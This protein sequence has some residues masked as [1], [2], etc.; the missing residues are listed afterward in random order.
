MKAS[1]LEIRCQANNKKI[2]E[3]KPATARACEKMTS[4]NALH[5][6]NP[7]GET[8]EA[9]LEQFYANEPNPSRS[10]KMEIAL[11]LK[12]SPQNIGRWF[13]ARKR[14]DAGQSRVKRKTQQ[15]IDAL[16]A[17]FD[18]NPFPTREEKDAIIA[19][20]GLTLKE[21]N[22]WFQFSRKKRGLTDLDNMKGGAPLKSWHLRVKERVRGTSSEPGDADSLGLPSPGLLSLF[23][24]D[25]QT[26]DASSFLNQ[27][28]LQPEQSSNSLDSTTLPPRPPRRSGSVA[29]LLDHFSSSNT[30]E[31]PPTRTPPGSRHPPSI[32]RFN[33]YASSS[34]SDTAMRHQRTVSSASSRSITSSIESSQSR[35]V[36]HHADEQPTT[37]SAAT[38]SRTRPNS[39][40]F[41]EPVLGG[42][43]GAPFE[44]IWEAQEQSPLAS[45]VSPTA[46]FFPASSG[47]WELG[48]VNGSEPGTPESD[49]PQLG[50]Q[51]NGF[52]ISNS[53]PPQPSLQLPNLS[54]TKS[55]RP[56]GQQQ[57]LGIIPLTEE[58]LQHLRPFGYPISPAS[59]TLPTQLGQAAPRRNPL[60]TS[61][62]L[63]SDRIEVSN[64]ALPSQLPLRT[65]ASS[66]ASSVEAAIQTSQ[67]F[68]KAPGPYNRPVTSVTSNLQHFVATVP[69]PQNSFQVPPTSHHP[70][71][72]PGL[73]RNHTPQPAQVRTL[74]QHQ[75]LN[76]P[77]RAAT[78]SAYIV[79]HPHHQLSAQS[80]AQYVGDMRQQQG[81][82]ALGQQGIPY[83]PII[84]VSK[85]GGQPLSSQQ[86]QQYAPT[87][88]RN[89]QTPQLSTSSPQQYAVMPLQYTF[90]S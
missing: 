13:S 22:A 60:D 23:D 44:P 18:R 10:V 30:D 52:S 8:E 42:M 31:A 70:G 56:S 29:S 77:Q 90:N 49:A 53:L 41:T 26:F 7:I 65:S 34:T 2:P 15:Q 84:F 74:S 64:F 55:D 1:R 28:L 5:G 38:S 25:N 4:S 78:P 39:G 24:D 72:F 87:S 59:P 62:L 3:R 82:Q 36:V 68:L 43:I 48:N 80:A 54:A 6:W 89:Q 46:P 73:Q 27:A 47:H 11:N 45:P 66:P 50:Q 14:R 58:Q 61:A 75:P 88:E 32:E 63:A 76:V 35:F 67:S 57:L 40:L 33:P 16:Q 17:L 71:V 85:S 12:V 81:A 19:E 37:S 86:F 21:I 9:Y 79:Q 20:A 83:P 69:Q 51:L